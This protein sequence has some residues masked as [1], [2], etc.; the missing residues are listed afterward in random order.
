MIGVFA[1]IGQVIVLS[2]SSNAL[3][4]VN[5]A[6][7]LCKRGFGVRRAQEYRLEL[8]HSCISKE[9]RR[10]PV[11]YNR[12]GRVKD[13][14]LLLHEIIDKSVADYTGIPF[15][16]WLLLVTPTRKRSA[17]RSQTRA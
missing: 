15:V 1:H 13:V 5:S 3:L 16:Q 9:K 4:T 6:V 2:T 8:I 7:Q 14:S 11:W 17:A 12:R 10:V